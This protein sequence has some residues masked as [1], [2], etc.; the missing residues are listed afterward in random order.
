MIDD[1]PP[2]LTILMLITSA[3]AGGLGI[4]VVPDPPPVLPDDTGVVNETQCTVENVPEENILTDEVVSLAP[5]EE[6]QFSYTLPD[7]DSDIKLTADILTG[8]DPTVTVSGPNG[9]VRIDS[10]ASELSEE[11]VT[12]TQAG[13]YTVM[14]S[15]GNQFQSEVD[16]R[17]H[18]LQC[19]T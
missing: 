14:L 9:S 17:V 19:R 6:Q 12:N 8:A 13:Q 18:Y 1:Y 2:V 11:R 3:A 7:N 10:A 15:N 4:A 5:G 16:I